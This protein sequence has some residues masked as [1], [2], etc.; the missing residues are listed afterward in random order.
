MIPWQPGAPRPLSL[1]ATAQWWQRTERAKA[2]RQQFEP[3][4]DRALARY[5]R[6][7]VPMPAE[8]DTVSALLDYRH[9]EQKK[10]TL[11]HRTPEVN[12][13]PKDP[14]DTQIPYDLLLPLREKVLN[15][16]IGPERAH[17]KRALHK[18]LID[19]LAA[20]G[21]LALKLGFESVTLPTETTVLG[22]D[23][24]P[25]VVTVPVPIWSRRFISALSSKCLLVPEDFC[26]TEFDRAPWLGH[27]GTVPLPT[28]RRLGWTLPEGFEGTTEGRAQYTHDLPAPAAMEPVVAYRE[29]WYQ[30]ALFDPEVIHPDLYRCLILAD[31]LDQPVKHVDSPYQSLDPQGALTDDSLVGNPIHVDTI[32]DL[33]DSAYVPSDLVIGEQLSRELEKFRTGLV[34]GRRAR[35]PVTVVAEGLGAPLIE[36]IARN[37]GPIP[38]PDHYVD[39]AGAQ[40]AV[41]V[42]ATGQES[43]D[44][45]TAQQIIEHD[46][47]LAMG[48]GSNQQGQFAR[49]QRSATEVR[50][51][52]A[53]S[54]ARAQT[55]EDRVREYV[56]RA[57]RKF[58]TI[59]QRTMTPGEL[60]KI[61]GTQAAGLYQQWAA[62]PGRYAYSI[63]P[64][65]GR[66]LDADAYR[67]QKLQQ[68]N[69]LRKDPLVNAAELVRTL[70]RALGDD[71]AK[72]VPKDSAEAPPDGP[73]I[74]FSANLEQ[75]FN[76]PALV[77]LLLGLLQQDGWQIPPEMA[78]SLQAVASLR[79][80]VQQ[81]M[82]PPHP[83]VAD[84]AE[85]LNQHQTERTGGMPG[86]RVS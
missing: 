28:A 75:A 63:Q 40:R 16:E 61:L 33:I 53:N 72:L 39:G 26:D 19:T 22:P 2:R 43:R 31:G 13:L 83:G 55:D 85:P 79:Q 36:Q 11:F 68:Y 42:A 46:W 32:R 10:A 80:A 77:P 50:T 35:R 7:L 14:Q 76:N 69:L 70:V 45:Y 17:L 15:A 48:A 25:Q 82:S 41:A 59:V 18:T 30:A 5:A 47:E 66:Y 74:A 27:E 54:T 34:R 81:T 12:L 58:D 57:I 64:D 9:V 24:V 1:E 4:W 60:E 86:P 38:V 51:V 78:Q 56:I 21:W 20:S 3:Q 6:P 23:G 29:I 44:N 37:E 8:S 67:N 84:H 49:T 65:A 52:Q 71:P 73:K 62:L